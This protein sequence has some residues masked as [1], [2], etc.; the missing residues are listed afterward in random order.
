MIRFY[1]ITVGLLVVILGFIY[2]HFETMEHAEHAELM[3]ADLK[4]R[5]F[6]LEQQMEVIDHRLQQIK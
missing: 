3:D 4:Y 1:F 2:I 5:L 6:Q